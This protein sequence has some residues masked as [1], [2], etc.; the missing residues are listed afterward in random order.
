VRSA[1]ILL[2][3]VLASWPTWLDALDPPA[4]QEIGE[5]GKPGEQPVLASTTD[6]TSLA[7]L[8]NL[9]LVHNPLLQEATAEVEAARGRLIQA[10]KYPNPR[11]KYKEDVLGT[12]QA[13][14]GDLTIE[15][16]QE[17]VTAGKRRLDRAIAERTLDAIGL[18]AVGRRFELLTRLRRAYVD[19]RAWQETEQVNA[20][21]VAS[22][23]QGV[24]ITRQQVEKAKIRPRTDLIRLRAILEE[25][26][27]NRDR[28]RI[29]HSGAWR[30]VAA[31]VGIPDLPMPAHEGMSEPSVP[32]WKSEE[33][34]RRVLD[35][36]TDLRQ[37]GAERDRAR[38]AVERAKAEAVPNVTLSG[39]YSFNFPER[40]QGALIAIETP[41]PLWDRKQGHIHE[42][43]ANWA[44]AQAAERSVALRLSREVAEA[45]SRFESSRRQ[46]E[47]LTSNV[48]PQLAESADLV[49]KGYRTGAGQ[50]SF[51]DVLLAEQTLN[52]TRLRLVESRREQ[53]QALADLEGLMQ[54][55][56]D[57][58]F[59]EPT[60]TLPED[61]L[62][63][64]PCPLPLS[65]GKPDRPR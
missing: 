53:A 28:A 62:P 10:S 12:S 3:F 13:P 24:E 6:P 33:V 2:S 49:R 44:R 21:I 35:V 55:G 26:K 11:F 5:L 29:Q 39:G 56:L 9:A 23:E 15:A 57:E 50:I 37:A 32:Q 25:A 61:S 48:L 30:V 20:E 58:V 64:L 16:S 34:L 36:H 7:A 1:A 19:Y 52:D 63:V 65:P 41:L 54:L 38:L 45:L 60:K 51:A 31:Q 27:L 40:E 17:L 42:A 8:W 4:G 47:G 22:L 43:Q 59:V 14:A 18:A 46:V